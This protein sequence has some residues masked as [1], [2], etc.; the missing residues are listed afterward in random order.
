MNLEWG[1]QR[2]GVMSLTS[3]HF[4]GQPRF[5]QRSI[6]HHT[7]GQNLQH[8]GR[9]V[10]RKPAKETWL[11][12]PRLPRIQACQGRERVI[13]CEHASVFSGGRRDYFV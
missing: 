6:A 13:D 3:S 4:A 8:T 10:D 12:N 2:S 9:F 1:D 11:H 7:I 5:G